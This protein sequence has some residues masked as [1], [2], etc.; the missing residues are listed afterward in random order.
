MVNIRIF[1][2]K[3]MHEL[4]TPMYHCI[5]EE[6]R[7]G[8]ADSAMY[9]QLYR[10]PVPEENL[11]ASQ[12]QMSYKSVERCC[13]LPTSGH[14]LEITEGDHKGFYFMDGEHLHPVDFDAERADCG[15]MVTA[16]IFEEQK[17]PYPADIRDGGGVI[18]SL[19]GGF[20]GFMDLEEDVS[21]IYNDMF[22]MNGSM[23]NRYVGNTLIRGTFIVAATADE[24]ENAIFKSLTPEQIAKYSEGLPGP[25][26]SEPS[27][28]E[29]ESIMEVYFS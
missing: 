12:N 20:P 26:D 9:Q 14:V 10:G 27:M 4:N 7:L 18:M 19:V 11:I 17:E 29:D 8:K 25:F 3:D 16:L 5:L 13:V 21:V 1:E 24:S 22:L 2:R 15:Q 6:A 23:P 28:D